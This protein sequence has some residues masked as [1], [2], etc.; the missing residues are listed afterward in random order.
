M[1]E[2][3]LCYLVCVSLLSPS[4]YQHLMNLQPNILVLLSSVWLQYTVYTFYKNYDRKDIN[5]ISFCSSL[6]I[7][8]SSHWIK[9][10]VIAR[11]LV[12]IILKVWISYWACNRLKVSQCM[13]I[14]IIFERFIVLM[15]KHLNFHLFCFCYSVFS[16]CGVSF[17]WG[18]ARVNFDSSL[19]WNCIFTTEKNCGAGI[20]NYYWENFCKHFKS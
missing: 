17:Y 11:H 4:L 19:F 8:L 12:L 9:N 15:W 2:T 1:Y 3:T 16:E 10:V 5:P 13:K 18:P 20:S 14:T 7:P 6:P